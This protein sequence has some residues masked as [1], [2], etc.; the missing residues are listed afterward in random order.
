M[1]HLPIDIVRS[2]L[3]YR[4][5]NTFEIIAYELEHCPKRITAKWYRD[6]LSKIIEASIADENDITEKEYQIL[7]KLLKKKNK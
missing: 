3:S 4:G 5:T 6:M 2:I 1:N 7:L